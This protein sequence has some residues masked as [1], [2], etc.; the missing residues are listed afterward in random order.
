MLDFKSPA[1]YCYP[2]IF[3]PL[4]WFSA[5][6]RNVPISFP[7]SFHLLTISFYYKNLSYFLITELLYTK[8]LK[9]AMFCNIIA[10]IYYDFDTSF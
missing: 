2:A 1:E 7:C 3:L 10:L 4:M 6:L 5:N 8:G 9:D